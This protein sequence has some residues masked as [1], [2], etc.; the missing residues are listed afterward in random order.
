MS[1]PS[2][3]G[4][5]RGF[6]KCCY[7][8]TQAVV[9]TEAVQYRVHYTLYVVLRHVP[10]T[11]TP[12]AGRTKSA[13]LERHA[14]WI[15]IRSPNSYYA[16]NCGFA[17][18]LIASVK[19]EVWIEEVLQPAPQDSSIGVL[20]SSFIRWHLHILLS[21]LRWRA[22]RKILQVLSAIFLAWRIRHNT[23]VPTHNI[24]RSSI[25]AGGANYLLTL[26]RTIQTSIC[27]AGAAN[28]ITH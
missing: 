22:D 2:R 8:Y 12:Y 21:R 27:F 3:R 5:G 23:R 7:T 10:R 1:R 24:N 28:K 11:V 25:F 9:Y 17:A 13:T 14:A 20:Y 19:G 6:A 18:D 26:V 16:L 15:L 4:K